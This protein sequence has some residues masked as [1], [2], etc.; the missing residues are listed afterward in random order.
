M[1]VEE[2]IEKL[3]DQDPETQV[4]VYNPTNGIPAKAD[5]VVDPDGRIVFVISAE[6]GGF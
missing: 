2:L 3:D 5:F 1:N 6:D 4:Y